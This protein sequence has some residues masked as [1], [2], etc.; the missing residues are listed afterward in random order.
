[1]E[2]NRYGAAAE[3]HVRRTLYMPSRRPG[4]VAWAA[5]FEYGD[6][7]LGLSFKETVQERDPDYRP[8][9]LELG[10]AAGAPV[11]Y[12]SVECGGAEERSYRVYLLSED[13]GKSYRETG[14]CPL[15][16]GPFCC[17]GFPD[18]RLIGLERPD[19]NAAGTG[20]GDGILVRESRD[21]GTT[22]RTTEKL[23]AGCAPY[24]W[25]IRRLRDGSFLLLASLYGTPWG[26]G[27]PRA[28]RNTMLPGETYLNK[29]QT[30]LLHSRDGVHYSGPHYVLPGIG[31]HEYDV[32]ELSDGTL[33]LLAGDVQATP[34]ARQLVRREGDRFLNGPLL[35]ISRG[36]PPDPS[37]DPQGGLLPESI[38]CLAGDLLVGA[39]RNKPYS[40]SADLGDNW[41]PLEGVPASL[42]QPSLQLLP[43]GSLACFGHFGGDLALGQ[44]DMYIAADLFRV[45]GRPPAAAALSLER[46]MTAE[47]DQYRNAYAA[48]LSR[49]GQ[50]L[51]GQPVVFRFMPYWNED[52]TVCTLAQAEAPVQVETVTDSEGR[53]EAAVPC[54]DRV[55]DIHFYYNVDAWFPGDGGELLP[56]A[57]PLRCEAAMTP[58]RRCP[59]PYAAYLAGGVLYVS[60]ELEARFPDI[61]QLLAPQCGQN[62]ARMP[63]TLPVPLV[64]ALLEAG[65]LTREKGELAWTPSIHAPAPLTDVKPMGGGDW[66]E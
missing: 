14:R 3:G 8:P 28:T 23:L 51:P 54:F 39:R 25:R 42:Y 21:G 29:I 1:M 16:E 36:G 41:F 60:Q 9:K 38:V 10:E 66:Y 20:G 18:G 2:R 44:A 50:P 11:S 30:F 48:V 22:W 43:D 40:C 47:R 26:D 6:G 13:G 56:C 5:A 4:F 63:E 62:P 24:L 31:A 34:A 65:V 7:R 58:R 64:D 37:R 57:S 27:L 12:C 19:R 59:R 53:A 32:A 61:F 55:A 45:E 17:T 46:L 52:G 33:L 15:A 35:P 49:G